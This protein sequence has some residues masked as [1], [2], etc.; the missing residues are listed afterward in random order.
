MRCWGQIRLVPVLELMRKT[1]YTTSSPRSMRA[2]QLRVMIPSWWLILQRPRRRAFSLRLGSSLS[3]RLLA[4]RL[5]LQGA[6][7]VPLLHTLRSNSVAKA[8]VVTRAVT[9]AAHS[10]GMD[11]G[12]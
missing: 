6:W 1:P 3:S 2:L 10:I 12:S 9:S 5:T 7:L 4:L 11:L 8:V